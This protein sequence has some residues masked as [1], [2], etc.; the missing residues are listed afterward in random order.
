MIII[1]SILKLFYLCIMFS[2]ESPFIKEIPE[3]K[4][5]MRKLRKKI[6]KH[7]STNR[8]VCKKN[9]D[10]NQD[11][12]NILKSRNLPNFVIDPLKKKRAI[13]FNFLKNI[14]ISNTASLDEISKMTSNQEN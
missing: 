9:R 14:M 2:I 12:L 10:Q 8:A 6:Y 7:V 13:D 3:C 4:V 5:L 1:T 11:I